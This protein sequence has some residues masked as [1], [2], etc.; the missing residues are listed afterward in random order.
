MRFDSRANRFIQ[1]PRRPL[2]QYIRQRNFTR[3][4]ERMPASPFLVL[5][6]DSHNTKRPYR[7]RQRSGRIHATSHSSCFDSDCRDCD[8]VRNGHRRSL[9]EA[10]CS[11]RCRNGDA[12][13]ELNTGR[14]AA[15]RPL[16]RTAQRRQR[17]ERRR[18]RWAPRGLTVLCADFIGCR[19][20]PP[21]RARSS[22]G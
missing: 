15:F 22:A 21:R 10:W 12:G 5:K 14:Q 3:P 9:G 8:R 17:E 2:R 6:F 1:T 11:E 4:A 20:R 18:V 16:H 7:R 19:R 13:A